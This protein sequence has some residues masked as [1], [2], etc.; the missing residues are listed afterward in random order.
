MGAKFAVKNLDLEIGVGERVALVGESGS[1]KTTL[2]RCIVGLNGRWTGELTFAGSPLSPAA[3]HR[4]NDE[5]RRIQ[6]IFQNPY[7]SM[8][9][10]MTVGQNIEEPLRFFYSMSSDERDKRI[11]EALDAVALNESYFERSPDQLSGGERQ[12]AAIARALVVDPDLLVCDEI[13]SALDV[14]VQAQVIERLRLLQVE[15]GLS[16]LFITHNLA[17]VRSIARSVVVVSQGRVVEAGLTEDVLSDPQHEYT[18]QLMKD[19]PR[20]LTGGGFDSTAA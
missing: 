3:A 10:R 9:P 7:A 4:S 13:T 17:V 6:Y 2:A 1:G 11:C 16:M 20:L 19:L 12:R 5:R 8:N 18:R 15:R 14:S